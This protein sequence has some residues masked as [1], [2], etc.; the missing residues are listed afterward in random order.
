MKITKIIVLT[1]LILSLSAAA[2]AQ[3]K[4][5]DYKIT[6]VRIVPFDGATGEFGEEIK[7]GGDRS[8]FN[9]LSISLFVA[10]EIS[11]EKGTF[12]AGRKAEITVTEGK[13]LKTKKL[14]QVGLIGEGGKFYIPVWLDSAMCSDV[15]ITARLVG[16]KTPSS[17]TRTVP[18][19][20][21]E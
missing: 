20:C 11:G 19:L 12:E 10:V 6:N 15:K 7:P 18:F 14:E 2:V 16:Q 9:D 1:A 3:K 4:A 13:K 8:F 21:G 17:V 5:A